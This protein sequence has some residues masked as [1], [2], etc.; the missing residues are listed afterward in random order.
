MPTLVCNTA[1]DAVGREVLESSAP[2][3]AAEWGQGCAEGLGVVPSSLA[4]WDEET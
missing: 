4:R 1:T 2:S 3:G